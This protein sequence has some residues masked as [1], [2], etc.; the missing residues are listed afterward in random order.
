MT[1][2]LLDEHGNTTTHTENTAS[3]ALP[4]TRAAAVL[5]TRRPPPRPAPRSR[6]A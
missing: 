3:A 5:D 4:L 2:H 6:A 1:D